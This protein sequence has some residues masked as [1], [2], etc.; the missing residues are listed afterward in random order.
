MVP[1]AV[2]SGAA[3]LGLTV[4]PLT[5]QIA[6]SIGVE[7]STR[8]LVIAAVDPSSDAAT[9]GLQRGDVI[10]AVGGQPVLTA[11]DFQRQVAAARSARRPS[12]V[13]Q[14]QRRGVSRYLALSLAANS[15]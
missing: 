6:R 2:P 10:T 7:T 13:I 5:P 14:M 11:A 12:V 9:K 3:T 4:Q 15:N 1:Q 8:G